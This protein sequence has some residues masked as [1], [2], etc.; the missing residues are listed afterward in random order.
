MVELWTPVLLLFSL[1]ALF[2]AIS[3]LIFTIEPV[4][5]EACAGAIKVEVSGIGVLVCSS[6]CRE[7][8]SSAAG[9]G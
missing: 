8:A 9:D 4:G 3:G 5:I 1:F 6:V 2:L 7:E